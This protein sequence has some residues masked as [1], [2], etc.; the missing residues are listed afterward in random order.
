MEV[1]IYASYSRQ[2]GINFG[3][4]V[5]CECGEWPSVHVCSGTVRSAWKWG[6]HTCT[7]IGTFSV[8]VNVCMSLYPP[9]SI[10]VSSV[11]ADRTEQLTYLQDVK[12]WIKRVNEIVV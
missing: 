1:R 7:K 5:Q 8:T 11:F 10:N 3:S 6:I 4:T 2:N 12:A 9:A